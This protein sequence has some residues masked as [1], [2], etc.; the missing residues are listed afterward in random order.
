MWLWIFVDSDGD[1]YFH[2]EL[3]VVFRP[4]FIR[5]E[6]DWL[7]ASENEMINNYQFNVWIKFKC[8][9]YSSLLMSVLVR[10]SV[11]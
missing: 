1:N 3:L 6:C 4:P 7:T 9:F 8:T 5:F 2:Y 10:G 11:L